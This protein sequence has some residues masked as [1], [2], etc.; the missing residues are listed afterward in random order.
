MCEVEPAAH[1][2]GVRALR[3]RDV[4]HDL[5]DLLVEQVVRRKL[6]GAKCHR[7][8]R[9]AHVD[10]DTHLGRLH[11]HT[12]LVVDCAVTRNQLVG[13][14]AGEIGVQLAGRGVVLRYGREL[15]RAEPEPGVLIQRRV[16]VRGDV[17]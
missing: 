9:P 7:T 8:H 17:A 14:A 11:R 3:E 6:L 5:E 15:V 16:V 13:Q 4:V 12:P 2:E 10:A 1:R